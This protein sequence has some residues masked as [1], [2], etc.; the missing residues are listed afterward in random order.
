MKTASPRKRAGRVLLAALL[1]VLAALGA[2]SAVLYHRVFI[3]PQNTYFSQLN[4][5]SKRIFDLD[6]THVTGFSIRLYDIGCGAES[7]ALE[8]RDPEEISRLVD[9]LNAYRFFRWNVDDFRPTHSSCDVT[10]FFDGTQ[11]EP[12]HSF[13]LYFSLDEAEPARFQIGN[14]SYWSGLEL[15]RDFYSLWRE[16]LARPRDPPDQTRP[17]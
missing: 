7:A 9:A 6:E 10:L 8:S 15:V 5:F 13:Y 4:V 17:P 14:G 12:S 11:P 2:A 16:Y 1:L 3:Q